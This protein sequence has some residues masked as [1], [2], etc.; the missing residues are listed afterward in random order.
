MSAK[1]PALLDLGRALPS[2]GPP[3]AKCVERLERNPL[4][5]GTKAGLPLETPLALT[6][7]AASFRQLC[8][9]SR[10]TA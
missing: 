6:R 8:P 10:W 5:A 1:V 7:I 9:V 4:V 2:L 3:P